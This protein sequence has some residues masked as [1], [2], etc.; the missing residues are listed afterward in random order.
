M[1]IS[2]PPSPPVPSPWFKDGFGVWVYS[3]VC[4]IFLPCFPLLVEGFKTDLGNVKRESILLTAAVLAA[5]YL[6]SARTY[7][8]RSMYIVVFLVCIAYDF[9]PELPKPS[10][11]LGQEAVGFAKFHMISIGSEISVANVVNSG[12]DWGSAIGG[13]CGNHFPW[14]LLIIVIFVHAVERFSWHVVLRRRF[15]DWVR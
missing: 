9:R 7:L 10:S 13:W 2:P 11:G 8:P 5:G 1:S 15:P 6:V 14:V 3:L 4:M 12:L